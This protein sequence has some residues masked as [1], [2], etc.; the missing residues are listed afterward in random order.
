MD[1]RFAYLKKFY[2]LQQQVDKLSER[3]RMLTLSVSIVVLLAVWSFVFFNIQISVLHS[4]NHEIEALNEQITPL[5]TKKMNIE[6]LASDSGTA[7]LTAHMN[8]LTLK[9]KQLDEDL[10]RNRGRFIGSRDLAKLLHDTVKQTFGVL[11]VNFTTF[12]PEN[13]QA[14]TQTA[15]AKSSDEPLPEHMI[16]YRLVMR[17]TYFSI[18]SYLKRLEELPWNLYWDKFDYTV[19]HYPQGLATVEFY[20]LKPERA[21]VLAKQGGT[22]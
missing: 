22:Q 17:G 7:Q 18:M 3:D 4:T 10:T 5:M 19:S 8:E 1:F 21:E 15:E 2:E 14:P 9:M 13:L 12:T 6:R 11:I 20:T 16:H